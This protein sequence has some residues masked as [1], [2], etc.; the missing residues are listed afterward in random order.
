[1]DSWAGQVQVEWDPEAPL[2]PLAV[3]SWALREWDPPAER[4]CR[5]LDNRP[6]RCIPEDVRHVEKAVVGLEHAC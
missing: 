2:T 5:T 6:S 4:V 1:M 3:A